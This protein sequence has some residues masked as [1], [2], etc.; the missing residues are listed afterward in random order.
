I[1]LDRA[2]ARSPVE[3]VSPY[4]PGVP[5][6][7]S[8][9]LR[10]TGGEPVSFARTLL[11][12]GVADLPPNVIA[13]DG[14]SLESVLGADG[15]AWLVR[16][17]LQD[18]AHARIETPKGA[19]VPPGSQRAGLVETVRHM[20]RLDED[21]SAFYIVAAADPALAWVGAGAGR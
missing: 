2:R 11:S 3:E 10:G 5:W 17:V 9:E 18:A 20:L 6:S 14:S 16:V 7:A 19:A 13:P 15:E 8:I 1:V 12:H 21:L 4:D